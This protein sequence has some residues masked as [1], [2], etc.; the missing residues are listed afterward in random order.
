MKK[1]V[2]F[3]AVFVFVAAI[4]S[5]NSTNHSA[6]DTI[7]PETNLKTVIVG[8]P[9]SDSSDLKEITDTFSVDE[10]KVALRAYWNAGKKGYTAEYIWINP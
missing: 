10:E 6:S 2:L 1:N 9:N 4:V 7:V 5:C 8:I 3:F